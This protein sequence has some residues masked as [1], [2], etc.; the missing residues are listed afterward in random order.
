[1][2]EKVKDKI[3]VGLIGASGYTGSELA[4]LLSAHPNAELVAATA[5]GERVGQKLSTLFPSLRGVCDLDL[6][7][8]D[9]DSLAAKC[10]IVILALGHGKALEIAPA[11]LQKGVR[12]IDLGADFRLRDAE[13]YKKWYH[14][15]HTAP[16]ALA[17]AVYGL[18]ELF[19]EEI[20]SAKL[21]ANP[22]CYPTSAIL[23][24]APLITAEV[25]ETHSIIVDSASGVSG[26]GRA[27][28]GVGTHYPEIFGDFKAYG[29]A[30]HR[31]TPEIEQGL[32]DA[33]P[34][35]N[36][37]KK[38][39]LVTFTAHLLPVARGILS[40]CYATPLKTTS[41]EE[42]HHIVAEKY[43]NEPFVRVLPLG[44]FPQLKHV[45]GSNFCDIGIE[46]DARTGRII[47]I[48]AEDNLLKGASGQAIQNLNLM[49]GFEET[50]G[51]QGAAIF[52]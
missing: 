13:I 20:K 47:L 31:H 14:L 28:F 50:A 48:S 45:V 33:A 49:C 41:R 27:A 32:E 3:K 34:N 6:E 2:N 29:V 17:E 23:A 42:V 9:L 44:E 7:A 46:V 21:V 8:L 51:L 19:R 12:V 5:S 15:T 1:M 38:R 25:I 52:P 36:D 18:P 22:G 30:S 40:T 39:V 4:R 24:L 10:E 37:S 26:A 16:E 43:R 11:L 35:S